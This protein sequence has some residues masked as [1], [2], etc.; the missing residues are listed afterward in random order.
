MNVKDFLAMTAE[1]RTN[2]RIGG[3]SPIPAEEITA[4]VREIVRLSLIHI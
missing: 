1:R 2:Y 3:T 4:I